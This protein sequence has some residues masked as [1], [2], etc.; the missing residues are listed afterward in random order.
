MRS[1]TVSLGGRDYLVEEPPLRKNMAWRAQ[2]KAKFGPVLDLVLQGKISSD[3][4]KG[5]DSDAMIDLF[6]SVAGPIVESPEIIWEAIASYSPGIAEDQERILDTARDSELVP[7]FLRLLELSY[8]FG[9]LIRQFISPEAETG[10]D[11]PPTGPSLPV[12]SGASGMT[13]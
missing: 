7:V 6:L 12:L 10:P 8:P 1:I 5:A 3:A 13:S 11:E 9:G 2:V 4:L